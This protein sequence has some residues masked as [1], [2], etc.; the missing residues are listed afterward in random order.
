MVAVGRKSGL[1]E[2]AV[3]VV[4]L[5]DVVVMDGVVVSACSDSDMGGSKII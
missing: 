2:A 5:S 3:A 4:A 1:T